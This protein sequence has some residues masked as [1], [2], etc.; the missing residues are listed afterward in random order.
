MSS[1]AEK[2]ES[3]KLPITARDAAG[4]EEGD[5]SAESPETQGTQ[6]IAVTANATQLDDPLADFG[7]V[8]S[9]IESALSTP[10]NST[11]MQQY[12][13][14]TRGLDQAVVTGNE[15]HIFGPPSPRIIL[16][17]SLRRH[18]TGS[19][20]RLPLDVL[21]GYLTLE[22]YVHKGHIYEKAAAQ[23]TPETIP[24]VIAETPVQGNLRDCG[25]FLMKTLQIVVQDIA[26]FES[27]RSLWFDPLVLLASREGHVAPL[28]S[29]QQTSVEVDR[30]DVYDGLAPHPNPTPNPLGCDADSD[31]DS[32]IPIARPPSGSIGDYDGSPQP[33]QRCFARRD[34]YAYRYD[35]E[36]LIMTLA[37]L[38]YGVEE[39]E[40]ASPTGAEPRP[41]SLYNGCSTGYRRMW[42]LQTRVEQMASLTQCRDDGTAAGGM[43]YRDDIP[44]SYS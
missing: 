27:C 3:P 36:D 12:L 29:P 38:Q 28:L 22:A 31:S 17:D 43:R 2:D 1:K 19:G 26:R 20:L 42:W 11:A 23:F 18:R 21:Q 25:I 6:G 9:V 34:A 41:H 32:V 4:A 15:G 8:R 40:K 16:F 37:L 7:S 5:E 10:D 24:A 44:V 39:E 33:T 14:G 30:D 35:I 13:S